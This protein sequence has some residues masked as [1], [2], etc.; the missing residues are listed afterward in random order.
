M[1]REVPEL[2]KELEEVAKPETL[3]HDQMDKLKRDFEVATE[4][5]KKLD[6]VAKLKKAS[7]HKPPKKQEVLRKCD[8]LPDNQMMEVTLDNSEKRMLHWM[9][10]D[11]KSRPSSPILVNPNAPLP[12]RTAS[13]TPVRGSRQKIRK[14]SM[15]SSSS[16][17]ADPLKEPLDAN[18]ALVNGVWQSDSSRHTLLKEG[19]THPS[20]SCKAKQ[21]QPT[22]T[23]A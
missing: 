19:A 11:P 5:Q 6:G 22:L 20:V 8:P 10:S 2:Q 1:P 7:H 4:L 12:R 23:V 18:P 9:K 17:P 3:G 14:V 21:G 16:S 15:A 13:S